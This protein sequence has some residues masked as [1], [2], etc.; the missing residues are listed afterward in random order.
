MKIAIAH[1][2]ADATRALELALAGE[3]HEIIWKSQSGKETIAK[4]AQNAPDLL[5]LDVCLTEPNSVEVTRQILRTGA[6][7]ILLVADQP[8]LHMP[9]IYEAM[10]LGAVDVIA[11]PLLTSHGEVFREE[12]LLT[13]VRTVIR[14]L[15]INSPSKAPRPSLAP[16]AQKL[17]AIGASTGGPNALAQIL[18]GLPRN[19]NAS[20]VIVQHVDK[21][22][23]GGLAEWLQQCTSLRVL[24]AT[25]GSVPVAGTIWLA[26]SND[27]LVMT[28]GRSLSYVAEPRDLPYRPSVDVFFQ[29]LAKH[30]ATPALAVLLTGMGRDGAAGMKRLRD[31][32]WHTIAQDEASAVVFG[33][34][35]AAIELGAAE[36]VLPLDKIAQAVINA[37]G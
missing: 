6:C 8:Q 17:V 18:T 14:I 2:S 22:F 13:K 29:S 27:H 5:L 36:K 25:K 15:G 35:K 31:G 7:S 32:G 24:V 11:C 28:A 33:M 3:A 20:I 10:G 4:V 19:L 23:V 9:L 34:P 16:R 12:P 26:G 21:E 1:T 30:W 37:C